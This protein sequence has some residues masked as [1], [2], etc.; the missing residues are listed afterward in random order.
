MNEVSAR[1]TVLLQGRRHGH[2]LLRGRLRG[3]P[4]VALALDGEREVFWFPI[5]RLYKYHTRW[6]ERRRG[7]ESDER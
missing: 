6:H 4:A 3:T 2:V 1:D 7:V 5:S